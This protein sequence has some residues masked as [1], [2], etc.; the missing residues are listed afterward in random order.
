MRFNDEIF[1]PFLILSMRP[2]C[3]LTL[4]LLS[5]LIVHVKFLVA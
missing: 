2:T 1:Y 5:T 3:S 4:I